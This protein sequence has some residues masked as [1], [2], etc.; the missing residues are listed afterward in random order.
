MLLFLLLLFTASAAA[1]IQVGARPEPMVVLKSLHYR[2]LGL[3]DLAL[4]NDYPR[5]VVVPPERVY[6]WLPHLRFVSPQRARAVLKRSQHRTR[7]ATAARLLEY[8]AVLA[9]LFTGSGLVSAS[10]RITSGL[11][12]GTVALHQTANRLQ[13]SAPSLEP[14]TLE[15]FERPVELKAGECTT[16]TAFAALQTRAVPVNVTGELP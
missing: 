8:G 15:L 1:Q 14:F 4:C 11:T 5:S 16:R 10:T 12:I 6:L 2:D 3:W 9:A 13:A 7:S